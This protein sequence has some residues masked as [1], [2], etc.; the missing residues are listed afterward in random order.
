MKITN[1]GQYLVKL[2]RYPTVFPMNCYLVR[3]ED[4]LTLVDSTMS[5]PAADV[6]RVAAE[7][8][9]QLRRVALTH[10]HGDHV[11]GVAGVRDGYPGV[12]VSIGERDARLLAGDT[13]LQPGEP[14][15]PAKG[16]FVKVPW[17][18]DQQLKPGDRV[19]SLE[20]VA[21]PGHTPGHIAFL[22][23]RD[24][25]MIAGDAFQTRGGIAVS[26]V[27]RP[28]FPFPALATWHKPSA[29]S[30]AHAL[31]KLQPSRLAVG[32]G[33]VLEEPLPAMDRAIAAAQAAFN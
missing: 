14:Q 17:E 5:S 2:T 3:E 29:R 7:L 18:P 31:R 33:D 19:G 15:V 6:A 32:H 25:T 28:L 1:H 30:S 11:G 8:G 10:A 13:S 20:V 16:W 9:L 26:G 27:V 23:V 21:S 24:R 4:G 12:I 22:D